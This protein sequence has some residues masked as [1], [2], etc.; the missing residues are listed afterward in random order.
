HGETRGQSCRKSPRH[1]GETVRDPL[2]ADRR[3]ERSAEDHELELDRPGLHAREAHR[4][5][6]LAAAVG[7][8]ARVEDLKALA[9]LVERDVGVPEDGRVGI[10]EP[11]PQA[12]EAA[13]CGWDA[14]RAPG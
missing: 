14:A 7:G 13:G 4:V 2:Q 6:W 12:L 8:A 10:R 11:Q 5:A 1:R 3:R 9:L